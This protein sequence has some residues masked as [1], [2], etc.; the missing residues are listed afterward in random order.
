MKKVLL[1]LSIIFSFSLN[2]Q[3]L[4]ANQLKKDNWTIR[5]NANNMLQVD[6]S[7]YIPTYWYVDSVAATISGGST[8]PTSGYLPYNLSGAFQDSPFS[9]VGSSI[10]ISDGNYISSPS[11]LESYSQLYF[12]N[13]INPFTRLRWADTMG[14]GGQVSFD[15]NSTFISHNKIVNLYSPIVRIGQT[16]YWRTSTDTTNFKVLGLDASNNIVEGVMSSGGATDTTSLSNRINLKENSF[17]KNTGFNKDTA[18]TSQLNAGTGSFIATAFGL[19]GSNYVEK[20]DSTIYA[21]VYANS[22]K[23]SKSSNLSDVASVSTSRTNL[24]LKQS[25]IIDTATIAEV[26]AGIVGKTITAYVLKNSTFSKAYSTERVQTPSF[27]P[28]DGTTYRFSPLPVAATSS[29]GLIRYE[30]R[31]PVAVLAENARITWN[32]VAGDN[33]ATT[34]RIANI[35]AGTT[36]DFSTTLDFSAASNSLSFSGGTLTGAA[37]DLWE[38]QLVCPTWS[39]TNPTNIVAIVDIGFLKN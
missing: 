3:Q 28:A 7:T 16:P 35:T 15:S 36:Y 9:V 24:G 10:N 18:T 20:S 37:N 1:F 19:K 38:L 11:G 23:L 22:L 34:L 32:C 25:A 2:A 6:T 17:S 30:F 27:S 33:Q 8:N 4:G 14:N 21:S 29:A 12:K 13:T 26:N 39:T 5:G 31:F